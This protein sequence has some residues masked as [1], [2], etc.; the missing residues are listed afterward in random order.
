MD[1]GD[2]S[3][4]YGIPS[5][6]IFPYSSGEETAKELEERVDSFNIQDWWEQRK[7]VQLALRLQAM[8]QPQNNGNKAH[9][10][11]PYEGCAYAWQLTET[12]DA[13]LERLPPATTDESESCPC[14][15]ICNPWIERTPKVQAHNQHVR[16]SE[17]EGPEEDKTDLPRFLAGGSERLGMVA[18]FADFMKTSS[19][20]KT[21]VAREVNKA[22]REATGDL[23]DLALNLHVRCGKWMIFC[24]VHSVDETWALVAKATANNELGIAAKVAP[25]STVDQRTER[26]ICVYTADFSDKE[27]VHRVA[28]KLKQFGLAQPHGRP[29]Y[30]KPDCYTYLGIGSNNAWGIKASIY[31]TS[32]MLGKS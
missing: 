10:H 31:N 19:K 21:A 1:S 5:P 16:G 23:L 17:N 12:V 14:I 3:D 15:F 30:Y 20:S 4:F 29:L 28:G 18:A 24:P 8:R 22:G 2:E 6:V 7:H 25:R 27:D 9:L 32:E 26:L 13:F 11:N